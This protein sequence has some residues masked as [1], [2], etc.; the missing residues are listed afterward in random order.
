MAD[1]YVALTFDDVPQSKSEQLLDILKENNVKAAF[2]AV[3]QYIRRNPDAIKRMIAEGHEIGNHS[4][5]HS[6]LGVKGKLNEREIRQNLAAVQEAVKS[7]TGSCPVYFRAP[8]FD[9]SDELLVIAKEMG[10]PVIGAAIDSQDWAASI[11][12]GQIVSN[13]MNTAKDGG[14]IV[15]H[16]H[17]EG[18]LD[19]TI[20]A[21]PLIVNELRREGYEIMSLGELVKRKGVC[22]EAG[23]IYNSI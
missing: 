14:I 5:D 1:K 16:E 12:T 3:G 23:K 13:V 21:I 11:T 8:Y 2:F 15:L 20:R 9:Y 6:F 7:I 18:D 22:L 19:R 4:D 17:S 10:M